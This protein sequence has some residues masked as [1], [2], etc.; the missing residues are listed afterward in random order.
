MPTYNIKLLARVVVRSGNQFAQ[1][2][3][4]HAFSSMDDSTSLITAELIQV[5]AL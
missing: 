1:L 5:H 4:S 2:K 3:K